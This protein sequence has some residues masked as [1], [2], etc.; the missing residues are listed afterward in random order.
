MKWQRLDDG[1]SFCPEHKATFGPLEQC[2]GCIAGSIAVFDQEAAERAPADAPAGCRTSVERER[3]FTGAANWARRQA[4]AFVKD[5]SG[6]FPMAGP[7]VAA[8]FLAEAL[9][10]ERAAAA[11]TAVRERRAY[12]KEL[13]AERAR[14]R[15]G[16]G[17]R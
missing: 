6:E 15:G 5:T 12:V 7:A 11:L 13:R 3:W 2:P 9:K 1:A 14:L 17:R 16:G 8:K 10:A 4:R